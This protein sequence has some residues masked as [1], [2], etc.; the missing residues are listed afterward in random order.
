VNS[1]RCYTFKRGWMSEK[2]RTQPQ[3]QPQPQPQAQGTVRAHGYFMQRTRFM[4]PLTSLT[5]CTESSEPISINALTANRPGDSRRGAHGPEYG[6]SIGP[7]L[8]KAESP[9]HVS[10]SIDTE[11]SSPETCCVVW[12]KRSERPPLN[13]PTAPP[14]RTKVPRKAKH[15]HHVPGDR[16]RGFHSGYSG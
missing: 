6:P 8:G 11:V 5:L 13:S 7:D 12:G 15:G 9:L 2:A 4:T 3:P 16:R 14:R 1:I 10:R